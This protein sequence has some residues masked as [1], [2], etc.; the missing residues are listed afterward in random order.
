MLI[1]NKCQR[2]KYNSAF[3]VDILTNLIPPA[4]QAKNLGVYIDSDLNF[5]HHIQN[6]VKV[7]NYFIRDIRR[8]RKHLNL[9]A[10]IALANALVSCRLDYCNSL[11]H[12]IP[13]LHLNKLQC[14]QNSLVRA[15]TQS[16]KFTSSKPLLDKLHW[17][18]VVSRIDFKIATLTYKAVHLKQPPS[19]CKN[20]ELKSVLV[21]TRSNDHLLLQHPA[22]GSNNY[23]RR[24]FS[25]TAPTV[26]N[27]LPFQIRNAPSVMCFRKRL[28]THYFKNPSRPPDGV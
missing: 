6:T 16:T 4:A 27:K 7:C 26:W 9:D 12:S 2:K 11:L 25:Y 23:G 8:V 17:L 21:K 18:P 10:S 28:K 13:K 20:L 24:A 19:L 3:P 1:G 5:Q 22:V 14:L 15:V